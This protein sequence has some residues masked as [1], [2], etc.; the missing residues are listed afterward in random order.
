MRLSMTVGYTLVAIFGLALLMV[1]HESGHLFAARAFG[2]RVTRFSIGFGPTIFRVEPKD[3]YF[4]FVTA[5]DK[6][7]VRLWKH[8]EAKHGPT[9]YQVGIIPFL[10]YVQIAGMNPLEEVDPE[11]KGS[12]A[13]AP[14]IARVSTIFGG[15]LSNY[16]F[17]SVVFFLS[18]WIGGRPA[19][20][21]HPTEVN[22]LP[23]NP[24]AT[25]GLQSGDRIVGVEKTPVSDWEGMAKIIAAN[26]GK[27]IEVEI[28]R[29][30]ERQTLDVTPRDDNGRGLIGVKPFTRRVPV[31]VSEA[32]RLSIEQPAFVVKN[33]VVGLYMIVTRKAEPELAGPVG[34][35]KETGR[36]ARTGW[37]DFIEFLAMLSAY[38]GAFNLIPFPALDGG[39]LVFLGYEAATRRRADAKVESIIHA[40]GLILLLSL[41]FWVTFV[42]GN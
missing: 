31:A 33:L 24:A 13:N 39:R 38:L 11:D 15:P 28:E 35:V 34:I 29:K 27:K 22:V 26:P 10:A 20:A 1:V 5:A 19:P 3:G 17:A 2:L 21:E 42:K 30:G 18:L 25:A 8:D 12:Y 37:T 32:A 41:V 23:D 36:V 9:I 14:L 6:V 7:R 16:L 4:W 40:A